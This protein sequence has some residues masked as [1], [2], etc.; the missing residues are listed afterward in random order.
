MVASFVGAAAADLQRRSPS[1]DLISDP[2]GAPA[3]DAS[4]ISVV[5]RCAS[6]LQ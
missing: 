2:P 6:Q 3:V 4:T 1:S 5:T